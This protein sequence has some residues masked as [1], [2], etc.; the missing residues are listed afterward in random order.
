MKKEAILII[1]LAFTIPLVS[2]GLFD[3][4]KEKVQLAPSQPADV[5][6]QVKN[7]APVI[8]AISA[9]PAVSLSPNPSTTSVIFTFR[10]TDKNGPADLNDVTASANF[11]KAGETTRTASC[12]LQST[13]GRDKT[14]ECTVIMQYFDDAGT[15]NVAVSI[16]DQSS[17]T[18]SLTSTFTVNLLKHISISPATISFPA[19]EPEE[20]NVISTIPTTITNNGNFEAPIDGDIKITSFDLQG[21]TNPLQLI[22]SS[23]F[24]VAGSSESATV[25]STGNSLIDSTPVVISANLPRGQS[26]LNTQDLI[27]CLTSVPAE[28]GTQFY[29]ATGARAWTIGI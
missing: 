16:Q 11:N 13:Q 21:E 6:V 24:K 15:W 18:A 4:L 5:R 17:V 26:G 10:A 27:Y 14:F 20:T 8:E 1:L 22:L 2:A 9:I 29:S 25:C 3:W 19:V 28:I 12:V 23:T 7:S